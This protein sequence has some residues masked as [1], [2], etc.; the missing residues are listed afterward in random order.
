MYS[1]L[2]DNVLHLLTEDD[3]HFD[4]HG[5]DDTGSCIKEY[6]TNIMGQFICHNRACGS[7][8]W[9]SKKI[10]VTIRMYSGTQYNA[11]VYHQ[12][13]LECN[14]L[15]KPRLDAMRSSPN[16]R[17]LVDYKDRAHFHDCACSVSW[18]RLEYSP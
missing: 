14:N 5:N 6:D 7:S 17:N 12:R 16:D 13:C 11:R 1:A 2:H 9:S 10:A 8:G 15:S 4:F 3:L 18:K